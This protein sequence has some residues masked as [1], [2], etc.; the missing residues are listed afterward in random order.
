MPGTPKEAL[1][2]E[3]H[4]FLKIQ[5]NRLVKNA[6]GEFLAT[7]AMPSA[8]VAPLLAL[9]DIGPDTFSHSLTREKRL[10]LSQTLKAVPLHVKGLHGLDKAVVTSGGVSLKEVDF[11][12]MRSRLISNLYII[13]DLLDLDRPSGGYSLQICWTTGAVAGLS[14]AS[15]D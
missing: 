7:K 5:S 12:T 11:R 2:T 4:E 3:L 6:L 14:A 13:G 9:S 8:L 1:D 15:P 10:T